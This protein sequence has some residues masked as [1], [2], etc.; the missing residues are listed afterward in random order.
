MI[1]SSRRAVTELAMRAQPCCVDATL[2]RRE[3][4]AFARWLNRTVEP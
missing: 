1:R 2:A 4:C 3:A